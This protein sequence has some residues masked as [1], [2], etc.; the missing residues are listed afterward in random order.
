[1]ATNEKTPAR[2]QPVE[3]QGSTSNE[4]GITMSV[5][6]T[7]TP[8]NDAQGWPVPAPD[9]AEHVDLQHGSAGDQHAVFASGAEEPWSAYVERTDSIERP[10]EPIEVGELGIRVH[11]AEPDAYDEDI[12]TPEVARAMAAALLRAADLLEQLQAADEAPAGAARV[13]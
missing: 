5:Q 1:M 4:E 7:T 12:R 13:E 2:L 6:T 8:S 10:G 11:V 3:G 9:W